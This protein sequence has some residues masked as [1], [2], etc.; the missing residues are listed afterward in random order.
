MATLVLKGKFTQINRKHPNFFPPNTL[1]RVMWCTEKW[2]LKN[3]KQIHLDERGLGLKV[4]K[5][6]Q[7]LHSKLNFCQIWQ[8]KALKGTGGI[9]QFC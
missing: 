8:K 9:S 1:E 3:A 5:T 2:H 6:L 7:R 4:K